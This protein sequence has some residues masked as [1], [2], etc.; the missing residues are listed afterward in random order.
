MIAESPRSTGTSPTIS[1]TTRIVIHAADSTGI[2]LPWELLRDPERGEYGDLARLAHAFLR[3]QPDLIFDTPSVSNEDTFNI[4]MVICRPGGP[5]G[6]VPFQSVARPLLE[7]FRPHRERIR[8]DVLRPPTFEQ[9]TRVLSDK[10]NFYHVLHFDGHG[11]FPTHVDGRQ[12]YGGS[13]EQGRLLFE[14]EDSKPREV[15]GQELGGLLAGKGVPVVLLNACQSGMTHPES[16]YPSIGNQLLKAGTCGVVAMAYS[17]YVETAVRFMRRLY[18]GLINGEELARAVT[19]GREALLAHPQ[20]PSPIG[21]IAL[22]DW[23]VPV[24]FEATPVRVAAG[25]PAL[26]LDAVVPEDRQAGTGEEIDCPDPSAFGFVGRDGVM[27]ELERAFQTE[28]VV[29]LQGMAGVGKT[30]MALGFSRWLRETGGLQGPIFF[31]KFESYLPFARAYGRVGQVFNPLIRRVI[32]QDWHLLNEGQQCHAVIQILRQIPCMMIWDN[33]EPVHG[34]PEGSTLAWTPEEQEELKKFL[35]DL[36]GGSTKV[37]VTSRRN[38]P[39]LGAVFRQIESR[40]LKL[41]EAQELALRVMRR[42][43]MQP[44]QIK[45]LP[46]Y[47]DLLKYLQGNPLAIQ[48]ILP[49]LKHTPPDALL[50]ALRTGAAALGSDDP[51]QGRERSLAASLDYRLSGL[52]PMVR[53]RLGCWPSFRGS[54]MWMSS[55]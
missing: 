38:E 29:L 25:Q 34:F 50:E 33:F 10:P 2:S 14:G 26:R 12:V 47:N 5:E 42:A 15:T 43:G 37:L 30:E 21:D 35:H 1:R 20:R 11:A 6:D 17:V 24:L 16:L 52:D 48:V 31:F 27:L 22:R 41:V 28:S 23:I 32:G 39:W 40:G 45:G 44:E 18:E 3:S 36:R 55:R 4:L 7:S 51:G 49:E 19:L 8:L 54:S 13:G 46:Q 9:L 53:K